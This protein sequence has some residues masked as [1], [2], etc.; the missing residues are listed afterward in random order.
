M[1]KR[2]YK[3]VV[4]ISLDT[5][6]SDVLA[7]NPYKQ[8]P[9]EYNIDTNLQESELDKLVSES[10]YFPNTISA[11]PYTS[12]SHASIFTGLWPKNHGLYDQYNSKLTA[13]NIFQSAKENG[14]STVFKTDFPLVLGKYLNLVKGVDDYAVEDDDLAL[15]ALSANE[16]VFSFF[17]FGQI[18]YPYG[19]H[20]LKY[21]GKDYIDKV[22]H[23]E[24]KYSIKSKAVDLDDMAVET[25][26]DA[27]DLK[28]LY[29]YK[30]IITFLYRNKLDS[31]LFNLYLEG[32]NYFHKY[33]FN[34][35][36]EKLRSILK[37]Q[38]YLLVIFG[39]HGEAWNDGSYGHH[40]SLDE[41]VLRVPLIIQGKDLPTGIHTNR[42]RT[43]DIVPTIHDLLSFSEPNKHDGLSLKNIVTDNDPE[44]D[45]EAFSSIWVNELDGIIN[46]TNSVLSKDKF[47]T[48]YSQSVKYG[49]CY[50]NGDYKYSETYKSFLNRSEELKTY[51]TSIL[52]KFD[53][54]QRLTEVKDTSR[55]KRYK[56]RLEEL[57]LITPQKHLLANKELRELFK[58]QGYNI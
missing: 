29:R 40:N 51:K 44:S 32:I 57:N 41:G 1:S 36:L 16:N 53:K 6:R 26:R 12:T 27:D 10:F 13:K 9:S 5:L 11:A 25:F 58:L 55:S 35:F 14:Y 38:D 47:E 17:H 4:L 22:N 56:K 15:E 31:D 42:V 3:K 46:R 21:G 19:F 18:H 49:A 54:D 48:D 52:E 50:Y 33:R 37:D 8:Y 34:K 7:S 28:L 20:N 30:R 2:K 45:R 23:L 39:D 24:K 43:I